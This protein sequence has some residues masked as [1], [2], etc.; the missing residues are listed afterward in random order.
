MAWTQQKQGELR[1][2]VYELANILVD[3]VGLFAERF[4]KVGKEMDDVRK[5]FDEVNKSL[6]GNMSLVVPARKLVELGAKENKNRPLPEITDDND[7]QAL[8]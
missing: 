1:E 6:H 4:E 7:N 2:R 5:A 8:L 3:R